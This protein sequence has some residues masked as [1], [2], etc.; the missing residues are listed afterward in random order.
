MASYNRIILMGNITRDPEVSFTS[1]QMAIC[2]F[3][4]ATNKQWTGQDGQKNEK[5]CFVDCT[6]FKKTAENINKYFRKGDPILI[7]GELDFDSWTAQDG[8]KRSKHKVSVNNFQFIKPA[9]AGRTQ[10]SKPAD[11]P[12]AGLIPDDIDSIPF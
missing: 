10:Y 9:E 5:V 7:E 11:Q 2:N 8:T 12:S 4:I 6:A 1:G 3:G